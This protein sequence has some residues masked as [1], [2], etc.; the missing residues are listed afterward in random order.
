M[1]DNRVWKL[2]ESA[3]DPAELAAAWTKVVENGLAA[4]QAGARAA[5]S[6]AFDPTA[7]ARAMVDFTAQLWTEPDR[8]CFR[9]ARPP[10]PNGWSCGAPPPAAPPGQRSSR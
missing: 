2:P 9:R 5:A 4:M 8:P 3:P 1:T 10:R 6:L 7:P